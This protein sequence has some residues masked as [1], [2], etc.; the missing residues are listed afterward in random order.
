MMTRRQVLGT[1]VALA[2]ISATPGWAAAPRGGAG[3]GQ[4]PD[5]LVVDD[6]MVLPDSVASLVE[7]GSSTLPLFR[8]RLDAP[9]LADLA[10]TLNRSVVLAGISS[11]ASLFCLE[12]IARDSGYR[13]IARQQHRADAASCRHELTALLLGRTQAPADGAS[14]RAYAPSRA[15]GAVHTWLLAKVQVANHISRTGGPA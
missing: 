13:L 10:G 11:G 4:L 15:D 2:S 12:R 1:G 6:S 5:A 9:G 3:T 8:L 7:A 14:L